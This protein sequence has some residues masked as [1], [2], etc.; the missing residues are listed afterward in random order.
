MN[1][2]FRADASL[3]IGTG[4]VMRCLTLAKQLKLRNVQSYFVCRAHDGHLATVIEQED[5]EVILLP[6]VPTINKDVRLAVNTYDDWIGA[7]PKLDAFDVAEIALKFD[8]RWLVV[9]HYGIDKL[10]EAAFKAKATQTGIVAIDGQA[11]RTHDSDI[12]VDP[13][14]SDEGEKRWDGLLPATCLRLVGP[15]YA[16]LRREFYEFKIRKISKNTQHKVFISFGGVDK[17]NLTG[18]IIKALLD[19]S[20]VD[21]KLEVLLGKTNPHIPLLKT[22]Y[23]DN[24][25][26]T[27]YIQPPNVAEIMGLAD[28][29]ISAGGTTI[30]ELCKLGIPTLLIITA[31]NQSQMATSLDMGGYV[32][33][34]GHAKTIDINELKHNVINL[35]TNS[36][37]ID[38]LS[39]QAL[40]LMQAP[41]L[42]IADYI[43]GGVT[44]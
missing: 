42:S 35:I 29:S 40:K 37:E 25:K 3:T 10:W 22:L 31:Q 15:K 5:F 23:S 11:N 17:F 21:I 16:L 13:T 33:C 14:Y 6:L 18:L 43:L 30:L 4:H 34:L 38:N 24:K 27:L 41:E 44:S 8:A 19:I 1:V 39:K 12:L 36:S 28:I 7:P 9:D 2:I 26:V 32:K 20:Q